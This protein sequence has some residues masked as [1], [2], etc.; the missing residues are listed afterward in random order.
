MNCWNCGYE[1]A[2]GTKACR[3]CEADLT[4]S[5]TNDP[6]ALRAAQEAIENIAPFRNLRASAIPRKTSL[7]PSLARLFRPTDNERNI[8]ESRTT[9]CLR[10]SSR[11]L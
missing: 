8:D 1:M 9:T 6:E 7:V 3:R 5:Q 4:E 2:D 11:T 10:A